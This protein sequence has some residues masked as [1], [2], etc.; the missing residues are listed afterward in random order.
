MIESAVGITP[1][2]GYVILV[3]ADLHEQFF[4][5]GR[6]VQSAAQEI[7]AGNRLERGGQGA[8]AGRGA[9]RRGAGVLYLAGVTRVQLLIVLLVP[10]AFQARLVWSRPKHAHA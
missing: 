4:S 3:S 9:R 6:A 10:E 7:L 1:Q 2:S 8:E 5:A